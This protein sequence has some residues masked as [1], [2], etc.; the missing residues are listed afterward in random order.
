[1]PNERRR[2]LKPVNFTVVGSTDNPVLHWF[3]DGVRKTLEREGHVFVPDSGRANGHDGDSPSVGHA[4]RPEPESPATAEPLGLVL[5]VVDPER[6]RPYRRHAQAT[7]VVSFMA[8]DAPPEDGNVIRIGYPILVRSLANLVICVVGRPVQP[9]PASAPASSGTGVHFVTIEQGHY[10][11]PFDTTGTPAGEQQFF[12]RVYQ[13]LEPLATSTLIIN[14]EFIPDLPEALW[15]GDAQ[16]EAIFR[17]GQRLAAMDLLPTP[18]PIQEVL[19]PRDQHHLKM[20]FGIGGLSYGNISARHDVSSFWMSA[21]GVDKSN[22][23]IV[24]QDILLVKGFDSARSTI[25]LSVPPHVEPRRVSVDAIEH[26]MIYTEHPQVGAIVHVHGWIDGVPS[27]PMNYPCGTVQLARAVAELVRQAPDP[28]HAIIGLRNHGL[29]IT[30][31]SL[32]EI[33]DRIEGRVRRQIP[34]S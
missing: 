24:G 9:T 20:L 13:R 25:L 11:V 19:S 34:M 26:W 14:N 30:G 3:V 7:F 16:T 6:P 4:G 2:S 21:S 28:A 5:N 17:A 18:F 22:L 15:N 1:M 27:T 23:R 10:E 12:Q 32:D 29:T 8:L 31:S 33:F